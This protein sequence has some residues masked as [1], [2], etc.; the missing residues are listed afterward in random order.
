[1]F[2]A[3][4]FEHIPFYKIYGTPRY[5]VYGF[6]SRREMKKKRETEA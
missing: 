2:S 3:A 4:P 5:D 6:V 1:M